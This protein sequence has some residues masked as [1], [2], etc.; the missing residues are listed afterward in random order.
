MSAP[1]R[2]CD[3]NG[4]SLAACSR[5]DVSARVRVFSC[6]VPKHRVTSNSERALLL[7]SQQIFGCKSSRTSAQLI[8]KQR[9]IAP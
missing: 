2:E 8:R 1:A 9:I 6:E 5:I 7:R 3:E 4:M